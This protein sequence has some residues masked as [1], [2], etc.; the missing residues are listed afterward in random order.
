MFFAILTLF[1]ALAMAGTAAAF[2]IF[3]IVA[4]FAGLPTHAMIM[5]VVIELGKIV[6]V[7][8]LYRNWSAA[9]RIKWAMVPLVILAM[10][11]TSM[12]IFGLLSKAHLE[13][14]AS[15][16]S[17]TAVIERLDQQIQRAETDILRAET[18][19]AQ[20]DSAIDEFIERGFVTR[21]LQAREAQSAERDGL[22]EIIQGRQAEINQLSDQRLELDIELQAVA[23][24]VGPV[25]YIAELVY[26]PGSDRLEEAVRWV[27]IAFIFVFDPMAILLLMA[28]NYSLMQ[29]GIYLEHQ[30][31][32]QTPAAPEPDDPPVDSEPPPVP[33][34]A[35]PEPKPE[36]RPVPEPTAAAQPESEPEPPATASSEFVAVQPLATESPEQFVTRLV[37]H[38]EDPQQWHYEPDTST[39]HSAQ[40]VIARNITSE[41]A[42][43]LQ[44]LA[45]SI[46]ASQRT[47]R[48]LG[49]VGQNHEIV[50]RTLQDPQ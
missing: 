45:R 1:T 42:Q 44:A 43:Q 40:S 17:N 31:P 37:Q 28:A 15:V 18:A 36:P 32:V 38:Y 8:W 24:E 7:S 30:Q 19:L 27:I 46:A 4:I 5:G 16:G 49:R 6:G 2:A 9:T 41:D 33:P 50:L 10:L 47:N 13:Q 26:G 14:T 20:L 12:G 29:R 23:L 35:D 11:L 21:G 25:L 3:G 39:L 22:R 48:H 34:V